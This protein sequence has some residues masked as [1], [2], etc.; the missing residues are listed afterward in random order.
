MCNPNVPNVSKQ[1]K[2]LWK[3]N[4]K[5]GECDT[6]EEYRRLGVAEQQK[7]LDDK[8]GW[9]NW[10][11]MEGMDCIPFLN[12]YQLWPIH[13]NCLS[14]WR[15]RTQCSMY[16]DYRSTRQ[17][18]SK[19]RGDTHLTLWKSAGGSGKGRVYSTGEVDSAPSNTQPAGNVL[20][21]RKIDGMLGQISNIV[22]S[23]SMVLIL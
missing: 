14:P 10:I 17:I 19:N 18:Q 6:R 8:I 12:V 15:V 13:W 7:H 16:E 20:D 3:L 1:H 2:K 5:K 4:L 11:L 23:W 9:Q 22:R 21:Q